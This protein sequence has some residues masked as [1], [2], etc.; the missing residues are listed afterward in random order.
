MLFWLGTCEP[1]WLGLYRVPFFVSRRRI[2]KRV[3]K[4]FPKALA[5]WALDSGGFTELKM[6]GRWT[7]TAREYVGQMRSW[8]D[9]IGN[10]AW[11][12][13]Q[14]WMCEPFMVEKTGLSV[15]EHQK[16]TV[17]NYHELTSLAPELPIIPVLQ[18]WHEED[19]LRCA[20]DYE[21]S[22]VRLKTLPLVGLG[23]VCR[24]QGTKEVLRIVFALHSLGLR[25]HGFGFK[26]NGLR[27]ARNYL[28]S[29]D[30]M[31]W[32]YAARRRKR[33]LPGCPHLKCANCPRY[34]L[35]WRK[36]LLRLIRPPQQLLIL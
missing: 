31:A 4:K 5:P 12:A 25:L 19:Y 13:P 10:M 9:R 17:A 16:R 27:N 28:A 33:P 32:S 34:A 36:R 7:V 18:G 20:E 24:R 6:F 30:S 26:Q 14:D 11:A 35:A 23:S 29:A 15:R 21:R 3:R 1:H 22:G 2:A 8:R